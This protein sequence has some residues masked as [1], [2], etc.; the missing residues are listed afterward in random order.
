MVDAKGIGVV[1]EMVEIGDDEANAIGHRFGLSAS[2][3]SV[4]EVDVL[5]LCEQTQQLAADE[6]G[7]AGQE[8]GSRHS[9]P[10]G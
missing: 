3:E 2:D 5:I 4:D 8:N 7:G 1:I 10:S 6:S 9:P